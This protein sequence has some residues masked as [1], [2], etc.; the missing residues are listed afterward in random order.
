M[1]HSYDVIKL[2][3][4]LYVIVGIFIPISNC[5]KNISIDQGMQEL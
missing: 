4:K 3:N 5:T 2:L 1:Y